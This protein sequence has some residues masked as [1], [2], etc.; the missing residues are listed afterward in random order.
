MLNTNT[1]INFQIER[2]SFVNERIRKRY[3]HNNKSYRNIII[4]SIII[5]SCIFSFYLIFFKS[6]KTSIKKEVIKEV[7]KSNATLNKQIFNYTNKKLYWKDQTSLEE[8]KVKAEIRQLLEPKLSF[9]NASDFIKRENPKVSV[10]ITLHNQEKYIKTIYS[11]I[12]K[13]EMKD[14]EIIFVDDASNDNSTNTIKE[15]MDK[16]KRIVYLKNEENKRAFYSRNRGVLAA[17]GEY[18]IVIDPDDLLLNNILLKAYETAKMYNLDIVHFYM[19]IGYRESP[20]IWRKLKYVS[21]FLTNNSQIRGIFYNS[22][23]RNL[24]EKLIRREIYVKSVEFMNKEFYNENYR[25]NDDDTAFFGIVHVAETYGF[26]E[27]IGYFYILKPRN[28]PPVNNANNANEVFRSA[29]NIIKYFYIQSDNNTLEKSQMA[30]SYFKKSMSLN[31]RLLMYVTDGFDY[32]FD[33]LELYLTSPYL[34]D[35][36]KADINSYKTKF[37]EQ[38]NKIKK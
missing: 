16:D 26:L 20:Y 13:Q 19:M 22:I 5:I 14:L 4:F 17:T 7:I 29:F 9:E 36:Q 18:L 38:K 32:I 35:R 12:Q 34:N 8:I 21:G 10:I 24:C 2:M 23:G 30:Y 31:K 3:K 28:T 27:Q 1:N 33:V 15:L 37:I 25:V 11:C 6:S